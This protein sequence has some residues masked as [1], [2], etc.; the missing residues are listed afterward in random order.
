LGIIG[1]FLGQMKT[2]ASLLDLLVLIGIGTMLHF[3]FMTWDMLIAIGT[4]LQGQDIEN[5]FLDVIT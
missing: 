1:H 3:R 2:I 4:K 5:P